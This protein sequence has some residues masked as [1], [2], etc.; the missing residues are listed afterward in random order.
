MP[1]CDT[2]TITQLLKREGLLGKKIVTR[3]LEGG[4]WNNALRVDSAKRSFVF[5]TF[6]EFDESA[7][8]PNSLSN[9]A[10]ALTRLDG[11]R[12]SPTFVAI[13]PE[14]NLLV[15]EYISGSTWSGD[16]A[17]VARLLRRK[18]SVDPHGFPLGKLSPQALLSEAKSIYEKCL[19]PE[20]PPCPA[21]LELSAPERL[22]LIHRDV[23]P[24][25]LIGSGDGLRLID[26]Q[27]PTQGDLTED[28][29][30]F[31]SPAFQI[32]SERQPLNDRQIDVFFQVLDEPTVAR[33]YWQL[34]PFYAWRMIA[35]C[36][37]RAETHSVA[38]IRARYSQAA[39]AEAA[40]LYRSTSTTP[41]FCA[42]LD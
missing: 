33:R 34:A 36:Q 38:A 27:C 24:N 3:P 14:K 20:P 26:W 11:L 10:E 18:E 29:Y 7:F 15:Y 32:V 5:K 25:N 40:F 1:F 2:Q 31:L 13:W 23:G 42:A 19:T 39:A 6:S 28:I 12:V 4:L 22:S 8:F 37:W 9:E 41:S 21:S 30:S 35:Y 17:P 16:V